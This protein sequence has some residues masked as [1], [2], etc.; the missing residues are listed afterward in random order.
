MSKR[1][2]DYTGIKWQEKYG[3]RVEEYKIIERKEDVY[4]VG[5]GAPKSLY[6]VQIKI[7]GVHFDNYYMPEHAILEKLYCA[8]L[9]TVVNGGSLTD[10]E[11]DWFKDINASRFAN[12]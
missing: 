2:Y 4:D 10:K 5:Y 7:G 3:N 6:L 8:L 9:I 12:D 1:E 11:I